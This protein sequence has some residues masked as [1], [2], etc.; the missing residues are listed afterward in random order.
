[1]TTK[2]QPYITLESVIQD[3]MTEGD[4]ANQKYFKIFNLAFRGMEQMGLDAFYKVLSVKLPVA[5]NFTVKIPND[6]INWTKVGVLNDR[7]EI[8]PLYNNP[9]MTTYADLSPDRVAKTDD[10]NSIIA[11]DW[12]A[13]TWW[14]VWN[15]SSF[16][17]IYGVPSGSPFV[18]QFKIDLDNGVIILDQH[19]KYD[20]IM[21]EYVCSP[22]VGNDYYL[23]VQ[24]REAL[25][26]WLW[27]KDKRSVNVARGQ[28]GVSRDLRADF[29]N[30]RR[31]AIARW[32]PSRNFEKYQASQEQTRLA[33]KT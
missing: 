5:D 1:M 13:N 26:A 8:I 29:Y 17:N 31:Q 20:Y 32:K 7:G 24:F 14:N 4:I 10:P 22:A 9:N 11:S 30:E 27:W 19:F 15:G 23:P 33:V 6:Y 3:Y 16:V 28:V 18:G 21:L 25:V 2:H 12:G